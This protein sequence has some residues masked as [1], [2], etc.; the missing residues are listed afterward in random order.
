MPPNSLQ[1]IPSTSDCVWRTNLEGKPWVLHYGHTRGSLALLP[2]PT[3]RLLIIPLFATFI[4]EGSS[5]TWSCII[6]SIFFTEEWPILLSLK[7]SV[8]AMSWKSKS[9]DFWPVCVLRFPLPQSWPA[10]PIC[11]QHYSYISSGLCTRDRAETSLSSSADVILVLFHCIVFTI[12][13]F[14]LRSQSVVVFIV[15]IIFV[16]CHLLREPRGSW[17]AC[18]DLNRIFLDVG[19]WPPLLSC[20]HC[21]QPFLFL[22]LKYSCPMFPKT[23]NEGVAKELWLVDLDMF[24]L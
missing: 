3:D 4:Q 9:A 22:S 16:N 21:L 2:Y 24:H 23:L 20:S 15:G 13:A 11:W 7:I 1:S 12:D 10:S 14:D 8:S 18:F 6:T 5:C 17:M 19:S